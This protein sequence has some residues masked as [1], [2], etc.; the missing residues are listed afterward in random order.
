MRVNPEPSTGAG[1]SRADAA[2]KADRLSETLYTLKIQS[3]FQGRPGN[4]KTRGSAQ[5]EIQ[6]VNAEG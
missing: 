2:A 5:Q 1:V 3:P 6:E 4:H